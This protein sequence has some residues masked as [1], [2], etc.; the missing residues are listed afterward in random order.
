[1]HFVE[2][3]DCRFKDL[4]VDVDFVQIFVVDCR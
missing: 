2:N 1:M 3:V 4:S